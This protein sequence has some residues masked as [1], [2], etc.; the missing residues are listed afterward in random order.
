MREHFTEHLLLL[1][2]ALIWSASFLLIKIGVG[3][4]GPVTLTAARM[5]IA[6]LALGAYLLA[7]KTG[8]PL[9]ARALLLYA[10]VGFLGNTLPFILISW[11]EL[12]ID[13]SLAAI[14]MGVMPITT[15]VL[16][17]FFIPSE[18]VTAR[19]IFGLCLGCGGLLTLVGVS[20]LDGL[21]AG[22]LG[23]LAVLAG[24]VS[25]GVTTVFVRTQPAFPGFQ[26][27]AGAIFAGVLASVPLAF[28]M[29]DPS[30][31]RPDA[32]SVAAV[33]V[34]GLL[35]TAFAALLYFRLI[36][37]LGAMVFSQLNYV[38]PIFGSLWGVALLGEV[39][40]LRMVAALSLVL[41]G[42]YFVQ[43]APARAPEPPG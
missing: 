11:G 15:F 6:A 13:S 19:R 27:A 18:T 2:L 9:H 14:M 10:V 5:C 3:G 28:L 31:M 21:G 37:S 32:G 22:V 1:F 17:H 20:A 29:E 25:Y 40:Q 16:A 33:V 41:A 26:M 12:H 42:I 38:I 23:Q 30:A 39:L 34:L 8:I 7:R 4:V 43:S 35:P 36:R 24:A